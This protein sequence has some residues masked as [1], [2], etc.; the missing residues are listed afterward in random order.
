MGKVFWIH[1]GVVFLFEYEIAEEGSSGI[2][3]SLLLYCGLLGGGLVEEFR[4]WAFT[5]VC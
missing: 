2:G 5:H 1:D 4:F 3:F